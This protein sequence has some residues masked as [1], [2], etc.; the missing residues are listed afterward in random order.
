MLKLW[1]RGQRMAIFFFREFCSEK[2]RLLALRAGELFFTF[3]N[4]HIYD[5]PKLPDVDYID[6]N[7]GVRSLSRACLYT[8]SMRICRR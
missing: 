5:V 4:K 2:M 7:I 1:A 3:E 6:I 8:F